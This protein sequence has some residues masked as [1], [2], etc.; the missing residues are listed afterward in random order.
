MVVK[1][2]VY[3][4][5]CAHPPAP[6]PGGRG[7]N[8]AGQFSGRRPR[9]LPFRKVPRPWGGSKIR[10]R[11]YWG[12]TFLPGKGGFALHPHPPAPFPGEGGKTMQGNF[13]GEDPENCPLGKFPAPGVGAK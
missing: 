6:F 4:R 3:S 2:I 11:I 13:R 5:K 9:K 10:T 1:V 12:Y 7:K 8:H